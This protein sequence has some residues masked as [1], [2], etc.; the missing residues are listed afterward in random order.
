MSNHSAV[1]L[2]RCL[3]LHLI[4]DAYEWN[5]TIMMHEIERHVNTGADI[6][7]ANFSDRHG[8]QITPKMFDQVV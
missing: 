8:L 1:Y 4:D 5:R 7:R 2:I 6:G 3:C